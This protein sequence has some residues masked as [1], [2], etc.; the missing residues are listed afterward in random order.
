MKFIEV[1]GP[2][3]GGV[4]KTCSKVVGDLGVPNPDK[5][6]AE[7]DKGEGA[8]KALQTISLFGDTRVVIV[9]NPHKVSVSVARELAGLTNQ[10]AAVFVG[11][12]GLSAAVRKALPGLKTHEHKLGGNNSYQWVAERFQENLAQVS[13]SMLRELAGLA[14]DKLGAHRV[15]VAASI[16]A[17]AGETQPDD[18]LVRALVADV[19][20]PD[21]VWKVTDKVVRGDVYEV[22]PDE[23]LEPIARLSMVSKKLAQTL[24]AIEGGEDA[25]G[26]IGV[27]PAAVHMMTK[28]LKADKVGLQKALKVVL[29]AAMTCREVSDPV[30]QKS[31]M[32]NALVTAAKHASGTSM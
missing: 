19:H 15:R 6:D 30:V 27:K 8:V 18:Q 14:D 1:T 11:D 9:S 21:A 5:V 26:V 20:I 22:L 32:E 31:V 25:A 13:Q 23:E 12:R 17:A 10:G 4:Q 24:A 16:L 3:A 29:D 7:K 2:D 28:G